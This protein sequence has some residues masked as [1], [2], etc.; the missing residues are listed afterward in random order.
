MRLN[1]EEEVPVIKS[2][3]EYYAEVVKQPKS[4]I[5]QMNDV[6]PVIQSRTEEQQLL[7][8]QK[9]I[10]IKGIPSDS[11]E[12]GIE[13]LNVIATKVG[14]ILTSGSIELVYR[15]RNKKSLIIRFLQ[16][17]RRND[18][19]KNIQK[20]CKGKLGYYHRHWL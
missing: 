20:S 19:Y 13:I 14:V 6:M 7:T 4:D 8:Q 10:E 11:D 17:H 12:S 2:S 3:F 15:T 18:L 9:T 5:K 16:T 1:I